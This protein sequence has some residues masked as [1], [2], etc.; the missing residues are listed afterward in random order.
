M[1]ALTIRGFLSIA[2]L[3]EVICVF[4]G[5][6]NLGSRFFFDQG[7]LIPTTLL[8]FIVALSCHGL[9]LV[10]HF[11]RLHLTAEHLLPS[12]SVLL[13]TSYAVIH[14]RTGRL[15]SVWGHVGGKLVLTSHR[16]VFLAHRGQPWWYRLALPL[17]EIERAESSESFSAL[18]G[19]L[20]VTTMAGKQELFAFGPIR[21]IE[22]DRWAAAILQAR[23][24]LNPDREYGN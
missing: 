24:R 23:Y 1:D 22:T 16:L 12:E 21:E 2:L 4:V 7:W 17:E 15:W 13:E 3:V 18:P 10:L 14:Y 19:Y 20:R 9:Q 6:G 8:S 5:V 11:R